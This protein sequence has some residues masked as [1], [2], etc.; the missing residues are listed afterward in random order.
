VQLQKS[1]P[2]KRICQNVCRLLF[3]VDLQNWDPSTFGTLFDEMKSCLDI[4]RL[5]F[6]WPQ[7]GVPNGHARAHARATTRADVAID[8]PFAS[9][10]LWHQLS[11]KLSL[12]RPLFYLLSSC[13]LS[14]AGR[15]QSAQGHVKNRQLFCRFRTLQLFLFIFFLLF[16]DSYKNQVSG[17]STTTVTRLWSRHA[18]P[19]VLLD[20]HMMQN[21]PELFVTLN[22]IR[23]RHGEVTLTN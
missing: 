14:I 12:T 19:N 23:S 1:H 13:L 7:W 3:S 6:D 4:R 15:E 17:L 5:L 16:I 22:R 11:A 21:A 2:S 20:S 9:P 18:R 8:S 10:R